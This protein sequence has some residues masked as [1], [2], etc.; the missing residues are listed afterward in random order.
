MKAQNHARVRLHIPSLIKCLLI[1]LKIPG[2]PK[3]IKPM[4]FERKQIPYLSPI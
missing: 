2:I 3:R 4:D 1:T